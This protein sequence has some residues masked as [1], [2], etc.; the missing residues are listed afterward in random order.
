MAGI[1]GL[2]VMFNLSTCIAEALG[3]ADAYLPSCFQWLDTPG[4][5]FDSTL[6]A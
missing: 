5:E 1:N 3:T 2:I 4:R 6:E